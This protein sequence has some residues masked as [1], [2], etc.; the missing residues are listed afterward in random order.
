MT[1]KKISVIV[2]AYNVEKYIRR[3]LDSLINQTYQNLEIIVVDDGSTDRTGDMAEE[4][5]ARFPEK[6]FCYHQGNR[7]QAMARNFGIGKATG[8][9]IGF[10]DSDDFASARMYEL[11]YAEAERTGCDLVTCGYYGC[12][13][14]TGEITAYQTGYQGEFNQSIYENP[15]ILKVNSPYPWNKLYTRELLTRSGFEFP[16]GLIFEDLCAVFPLFLDA[17]K[18]GRVHE[19]LY[20]YIKGRKG[21]TISTFNEKH[22]QIIDAL[23]IMNDA[24]RSRGEFERFY[25]ILLFFNIRHIFARFDEMKDSGNKAFRKE[26][27]ERAYA[28]LDGTFPGWRESAQF[29]EVRP[30]ADGNPEEESGHTQEEESGQIPEGESGHT[31]EG[32]SRVPDG[33]G[34]ERKALPAQDQEKEAKKNKGKRRAEIFDALV[35]ERKIEKNTVLIE[36]HHGNDLCGSSYYMR[37]MLAA[38]GKYKVYVAA[39]DAGKADQFRERWEKDG[40]VSECTLLDMTSDRYLEVLATAAYVVTNRAFAGFYRKRRGQKFIFT[41]FMPSLEAQGKEVTYDTKNMQGTQFSLAQ[42]DAVLFPAEWKEEFIPLLKCYSMDEVCRGKGW[43]VPVSD[44]FRDWPCQEKPDGVR[45]AYALSVKAFPGLKDAK[46]YLFLSEL[47]KK[48][49][50]LDEQL[51]DGRTIVVC[52]PR[53]VRRRFREN[54]WKHIEFPPEGAEMSEVLAGCHG[55]IGEYGE[56]LYLMKALGKP[57]C[58]FVTDEADVAWSRGRREYAAVSFE[59]FDTAEQVAQWVNRIEA[60]PEGEGTAQ[61]A[62]MDECVKKCLRLFSPGGRKKNRRQKRKIAYLPGMTS[63]KGLD[64]FLKKQ[65]LERTLFF[66]EKEKLDEHMAAWLKEWEPSIRYMVII[67]SF[68][69]GRKESLLIRY[70]LATKDQLKVRRDRERY[71][72]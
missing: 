2:P 26:F 17:E 36:C 54:I 60:T 56:E 48:L 43:F 9:Y 64:A 33:K 47:K 45:I 51:E 40:D 38:S 62:H 70:K 28:L 55:L 21:G 18:V 4:Y 13:A 32:E 35:E 15:L 10:V 66:I 12:D 50:E 53:L 34:G 46:C 37:K 3:C 68:V 16:S 14:A 58:R 71:G 59:T 30:G 5:A 11:L 29:A 20:Y 39:A 31:Q 27:T 23:Q 8:E 67:R 24:Y 63:R 57:V 42:A 72:V 6:V 25:E 44:F 41:D 7:G 65:D 49:T 52:F 19:K 61:A 22:G 69:T 1:E